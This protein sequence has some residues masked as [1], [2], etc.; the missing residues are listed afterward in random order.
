MTD[1]GPRRRVSDAGPGSGWETM[2][3]GLTRGHNMERGDVA[4]WIGRGRVGSASLLLVGIEDIA[5]KSCR[6]EVQRRFVDGG[7]ERTVSGV[8]NWWPGCCAVPGWEMARAAGASSTA[9]RLL[10]GR[11]DARRLLGQK[12]YPLKTSC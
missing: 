6:R 3:G 5:M 12:Q 8:A 7:R 2:G 1:E 10:I 4:R 9:M 11:Q